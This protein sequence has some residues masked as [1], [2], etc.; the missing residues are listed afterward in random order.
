MANGDEEERRDSTVI[1]IEKDKVMNIVR[2][3]TVN[4]EKTE[5]VKRLK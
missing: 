2:L 4:E 5:T 3:K 1:K